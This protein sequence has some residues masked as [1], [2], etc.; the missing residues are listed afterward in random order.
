M[1]NCI[2][3]GIF[4]KMARIENPPLFKR[5]IPNLLNDS[6]SVQALSEMGRKIQVAVDTA[7][8]LLSLRAPLHMQIDIPTQKT[9]YPKAVVH[10][11]G[12]RTLFSPKEAVLD[13]PT[14]IS[15]D[16]KE[17]SVTYSDFWLMFPYT[18]ER[19]IV[20]VWDEQGN[21]EQRF[22]LRNLP[23]DYKLEIN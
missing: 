21:L 3:H 5:I 17:Q 8:T 1:H 11:R 6:I 22:R 10:Y 23:K 16:E 14:R 7:G 18:G 15:T 20:H 4:L 2:H 19:T 9:E 13:F 12:S